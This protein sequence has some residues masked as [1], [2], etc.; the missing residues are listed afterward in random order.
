MTGTVRFRSVGGLRKA[1]AGTGQRPATALNG[2]RQQKQRRGVAAL[3][4]SVSS[5]CLGS[6]GSP[7]DQP[8]GNG[9]VGSDGALAT[10][11]TLGAVGA[12]ATDGA[13]SADGALCADG[14]LGADGPLPA[15]APSAP[16]L[17][18]APL[19]EP[20]PEPP[21]PEPPPEEARASLNFSTTGAA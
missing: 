14:P 5:G 3:P 8:A 12:L 6:A 18:D 1:F 13:L 20:P 10:L 15:D 9:T 16:A 19:P 4:G 7:R 11:G 21:L 17:P 2:G